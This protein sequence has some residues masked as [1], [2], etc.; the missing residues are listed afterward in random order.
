MRYFFWMILISCQGLN[1]AQSKDI[2]GDWCLVQKKGLNE[3]NYGYIK[4]SQNKL[5]E[6]SSRTDTVFNYKYAVDKNK[7]LIYRYSSKDTLI[8]EIIKLTSDSLVLSSLI[9]KKERQVYY[10]WYCKNVKLERQ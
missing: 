3:L 1:H 2:T 6:L 5:I 7:L 9:E 8:S 10:R 4:F